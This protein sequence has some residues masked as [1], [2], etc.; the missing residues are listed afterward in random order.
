MKKLSFVLLIIL[1]FVLMHLP[2]VGTYLK[3]INTLFH[4]SSHALMTVM[5]Q[6]KVA[7]IALLSNTEGVTMSYSRGFASFLVSLA[8]YVGASLFGLFFSYLY[9]RNRSKWIV[10]LTI[11][12]MIFDLIFWVRNLY[13]M[14]WI[15]VMIAI[16]SFLSIKANRF[17]E[18]LGFLITFILITQSFFT[19]F[20]IV[21]LS[22]L[23]PL[24]AG[25]ATNLAHITHIPALLWS[26]IFFI[27][28]LYFF[29]LSSKNMLSKLR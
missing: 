25:D 17:V 26:L 6:G 21:T 12:L 19:T 13:G 24:Q 10:R 28:A 5:T 22:Y 1:S 2:F 23:T 18:F 15:T 8:G 14:I 11:L 7:S 3:L 4:E 20:D 29:I 9:K 16:I 27:Q